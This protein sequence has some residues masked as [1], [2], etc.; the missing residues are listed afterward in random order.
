[1]FDHK[2]NATF[3]GFVG[4]LRGARLVADWAD[5]WGGEGGVND[6]PN[7]RIPAVGRFEAWWEE[8]SKLWA[9]GVVTISTVLRDRA[10][11]LGCPSAQVL[12]LPTGAPTG[13]IQPIPVAEARDRLDV[14]PDRSLMGFIGQGQ[15]DLDQVM[16]AMQQ[17]PGLWLMLIGRVSSRVSYMAESYGVADRLWQTGF[18]P[19]DEVGLYLACCEFM[20]LPLSDRAANRGRLPNK[21][22]DYMAA[23]R[24]VVAS[25]VGDVGMIL[26]KHSVGL[27]VCDDFIGPILALLADPQ[28]RTQLGENAR[29]VAE[30]V[31]SWSRSVD[32]LEAFYRR[33]LEGN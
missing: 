9:D 29:Q 22:L 33:L 5:W 18:I 30:T 6:V 4:R 2:P 1:M 27:P 12:Y 7:R 32:R 23:A 24:P 8:K 16:K 3:G 10:V 15:G 14:P 13:R 28:L 19:D 17:I 31:F 21:L 25:Q 20:V 11:D 26:E